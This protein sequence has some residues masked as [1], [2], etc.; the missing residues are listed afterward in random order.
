MCGGG[1]WPWLPPFAVRAVQ[2][3]GARSMWGP[4]RGVR[5]RWL[6]GMRCGIRWRIDGGSEV[7]WRRGLR[8]SRRRATPSPTG[9][10]RWPAGALSWR[11]L[12]V[13]FPGADAQAHRLVECFGARCALGSTR[14]S[15]ATAAA[16]ER[17]LSEAGG[18]GFSAYA[19]VGA[20]KRRGRDRVPFHEPPP[21]DTREDFSLNS[22]GNPRVSF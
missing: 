1:A 22:T 8:L 7:R 21:Y 20:S 3:P 6:N 18:L 5:S 19:M 14:L 10:P 12:P 9:F 16:A 11:L 13:R 2:R 17:S 15:E 4:G